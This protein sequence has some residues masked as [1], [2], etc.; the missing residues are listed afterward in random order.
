[1]IL[2]CAREIVELLAMSRMSWLQICWP[3]LE[4]QGAR[5]Y[6]CDRDTGPL[7]SDKIVLMGPDLVWPPL[8]C[9]WSVLFCVIGKFILFLN[10]RGWND[11]TLR[12]ASA[13]RKFRNTFPRP[14]WRLSFNSYSVVYRAS[15]T[16]KLLFCHSSTAVGSLGAQFHHLFRVS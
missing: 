14:V 5:L 2:I 4:L 8:F 13:C 15:E 6:C 12:A 11:W 9:N 10:C 1:M 7:D 3:G 16:L